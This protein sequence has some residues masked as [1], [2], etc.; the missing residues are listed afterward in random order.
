MMTEINQTVNGVCKISKTYISKSWWKNDKKNQ[1]RVWCVLHVFVKQNCHVHHFPIEQQQSH[2]KWNT[3]S[4]Q[5]FRFPL[6]WPNEFFF[7]NNFRMW[8]QNE[9]IY[10]VPI[11]QVV[12]WHDVRE[13][14]VLE[15]I[16]FAFF[17]IE[18]YERKCVDDWTIVTDPC[19]NFVVSWF[20][21]TIRTLKLVTFSLFLNLL[22]TCFTSNVLVFRV[23]A[24]A[25]TSAL[26]VTN[27]F[28][29]C[30]FWNVRLH[31]FVEVWTTYRQTCHMNDLNFDTKKQ[32]NTMI[33]STTC[34]LFK[35]RNSKANRN[36][37]FFQTKTFCP[38]II[39]L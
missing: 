21:T 23:N 33:N 19:H 31:V 28:A 24:I 14:Q 1:N 3:F 17:Q 35:F 15:L 20:T 2:V 38:R 9:G 4:I 18:I 37:H 34:L 13:W 11:R 36:W 32:N 8:C 29:K 5:K 25:T 39:C 12:Q 30:I 27:V 22:I 10:T 6:H 16:V 7:Q 26:H